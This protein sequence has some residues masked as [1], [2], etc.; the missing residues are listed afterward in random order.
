MIVQGPAIGSLDSATLPPRMARI[1]LFG[2]PN[3]GKTTVFNALTGLDALTAAHPF[4][5]TEPNVGVAKVPDARLDDAAALERS[6]K[7]VYA[8]LDLLDLPAMVKA[9]EGLGAGFIGRLREMDAL[10]AVL[11]AHEDE[12][13][14]VEAGGTDPVAQA[15]DLLVELTLA[16]FEVFDRRKDRIAREAMA[17]PKMKPAAVAI[18]AGAAFLEEGSPLRS[19][20]WSDVQ[21]KAFSDLAPLTIVPGIWVINAAEENADLR[22]LVSAVAEVVPRGDTVVAISAAIE[23]EAARLDP[24]DRQELY[25]GLGLGE[26]ALAAMVGAAY[27]ALGLLSFYTVG[28][29]ESRAWTVRRGATAPEAAGKIHSDLERGFIRVEVASLDDV[30]ANGGWDATKAAAKSQP[31]LMRLEGKDYIVQDDDVLVVRFSV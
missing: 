14:P 31:G 3:S 13:V 22:S 17:D 30:I 10:A 2:F 27:D 26:G 1:G 24:A 29:K 15:E 12:A 19:G 25:E 4:S 11:R 16:D 8:T 18:A 28:P 7:T 21:R 9:G 20:T 6:T 23:E 5:T